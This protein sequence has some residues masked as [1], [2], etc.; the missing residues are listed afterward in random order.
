MRAF[1]FPGQASQYVGM[2]ADLYSE[3]EIVREYFDKADDILNMDLKRTCFNGPDEKLV[4]T[5]YTQPAIFVHSVAVDAILRKVGF[6]PQ[7]A[8]GHSLGEYSALVSA[9][10]LSFEDGLKTVKLRSQLMQKCCDEYPGTMAAIVGL[11]YDKVKDVVNDIDG[12]VPAN[13]N[14]PEQVA[15]SGFTHSVETACDKLKETGAKRAIMLAVS[16]AYHSPQM[17]YAKEKMAEYI[18]SLE[19]GKFDFP[20]IANVTAEAVDNPAKIKSLLCEQ[21][22]SPVLWYPSIL[23]MM[24]KG[25]R[26]FYEVGPGKVLK[27]LLKRFLKGEQYSIFNL[28][29]VEQVNIVIGAEVG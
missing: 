23:L 18:N 8:A 9:G 14:S 19:F 21:I 7:L 12:V 2:A 26:E 10:V 20:V 1:L 16:G 4:R 24:K 5:E 17:Q 29:K 28:D 6:R 11:S 13:Y 22:I 25:V 3:F 15:I 27:G